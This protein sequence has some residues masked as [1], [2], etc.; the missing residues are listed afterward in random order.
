MI[1]PLN[2]STSIMKKIPILRIALVG[3]GK[4][5][6]NHVSQIQHIPDVKLVAVC[7]REPLM[8]EQLAKR[9]GVPKGYAEY[10]EMLERESPNV[11]HITTPP[12]SHF[13]LTTIA[14]AYGCHVMVE[15]PMTCSHLETE[16]LLRSAQ[17][18]DRKLTVAWGYY[19]DPIAREMRKRIQSG[20]LGDIV[21]LNSHFGYDLAGPFGRPVFADSHHWVREL[22]AKLI[23][24]VGDHIFNK[25]VEFLSGTEPTLETEVW[26]GTNAPS[27]QNIPTE[28]RV[29]MRAGGLSA[30]A[31]F[32]SSMRPVLH[33]FQV[34]GT[35][36]A[37]S[38]DFA[39]GILCAYEAP[40]F[41]GVIG[42]LM[43][44]YADAWRRLAYS[45][46]NAVG[47]SKGE[48]GHF[49]GLRFLFR[50]F[51][52]SISDDCPPPIPYGLILQV[53]N[54][55]DRVLSQPRLAAC[56]EERIV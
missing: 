30:T 41:R 42:S 54:L 37:L 56:Q 1:P 18:A 23:Y 14:F 31:I 8:A 34:F 26:S 46:K 9:Y 17:A 27:E 45:S 33:Q 28:M 22:P 7:D 43:S 35:R 52:D 24:N 50:S 10:A 53:S 13:E 44:G 15:K 29:L 48:F 47:L 3:C 38:L 11:V 6:E 4:A 20:A 32:S 39:S 25:I 16:R 2:L 5:A 51:Y 19:F 12:Q 40:R 55:M 21:H 49:A 36:G